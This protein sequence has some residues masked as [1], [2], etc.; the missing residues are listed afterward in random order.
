MSGDLV[1]TAS[2]SLERTPLANLLVYCLD[3]ALSGTLVLESPDGERHAI[4][5]REG[6]PAKIRSGEAFLDLAGVLV[7]LGSLERSTLDAA[8]AGL[9]AGAHPQCSALA[10]LGLVDDDTLRGGLREQLL[11]KLV[12]LFELPDATVYAFYDGRNLLETWGGVVDTPIDPLA[13]ICLGVRSRPND[14]RV[15]AALGQLGEMVLRL[16]VD[17]DFRRFRLGD[18]TRGVVDLL[19]VKPCSL[20]QLTASGVG[21]DRDVRLVV[22]TF[23]LTRHLDIG[24][25]KAPVGTAPREASSSREP[26]S[27]DPDLRSTG[28]ALGKVKLRGGRVRAA[29]EVGPEIPVTPD[30]PPAV[31]SSPELDARRSEIA[32]RAAKIDKEDYFTML[33]IPREAGPDALQSAYFALAKKWHPDRL[34]EELGDAREAAG[35]VFARLTEAFQTL[36]DGDKRKKYVDALKTGGATPE[37]Q[38]KVAKILEAQMEFQKAEILFKKGDLVNAERH[39]Q[40]AAEK[41][42]EQV[43]YS[44]LILWIRAQDASL[45][46]DALVSLVRDFDLLLAAEP[47]HQRALWYRGSLHKRLGNLEKSIRDF[48]KL[49]ELDAK[50]TDAVRE[51]RIYEMRY[52]GKTTT[53]AKGASPKGG[54]TEE[55]SNVPFGDLLGKLFKK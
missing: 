19:R 11:R 16:H 45:A 29:V 35:K 18:R 40:R 6:W 32:E 3:R 41:D 36:T 25:G 30:A 24:S 43:D 7:E 4:Y 52:G 15:D 44:A 14:P 39:A 23:L 31:A 17:G 20:A 37:E 2:G 53:A 42:G 50:H 5:F 38:E 22:Y 33:G 47:N 26:L 49:V 55:K 54:K 12:K 34:P 9:P 21:T 8:L 46:P 10:E 48:R 28:N 13:A 51:L 1:A 27:S